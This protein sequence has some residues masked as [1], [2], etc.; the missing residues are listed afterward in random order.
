MARISVDI[1][2]DHF[3]AA[4]NGSRIEVPLE[5]GTGDFSSTTI[6]TSSVKSEIYPRE[7]NSWFSDT[8]GIECSLVAM[9]RG[10]KRQVNPYYAV[11]KSQDVVSFADGYPFTLLG[12]ASLADLNS[13]LAESVPMNR[14]RPNFVVAGSEAFAEDTWKKIRIGSSV[15][16]AVKPCER[17]VIT[18]IDQTTGEKTGKEPLKTLASYRTKN[19]KVLFGQNLIA[20]SAGG[21]VRVGDGIEIL[22]R[23]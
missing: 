22:E 18:T 21:A 8:L 2:G 7:I 13:R 17:C 10:A 23:K 12:E 1:D 4:A 5:P 20:E 3:A 11:R 9:P 19:Q 15:F 14:F 16:H 6:W